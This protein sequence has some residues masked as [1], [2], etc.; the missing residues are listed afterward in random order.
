[1][2]VLQHYLSRVTY[3]GY[4]GE[5]EAP[6]NMARRKAVAVWERCVGYPTRYNDSIVLDKGEDD[7]SRLF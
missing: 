3:L 5:D 7:R 4:V 6:A 2:S 1:M